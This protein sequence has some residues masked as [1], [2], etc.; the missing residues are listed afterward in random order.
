MEIQ[1][2]SLQREAKHGGSSKHSWSTAQQLAG[3]TE[4]LQDCCACVQRGR[5]R[6]SFFT[7]ISRR[8]KKQEHK[9]TAFESS[10]LLQHQPFVN[11]F[12]PFSLRYRAPISTEISWLCYVNWEAWYWELLQTLCSHWT[13]Q[14]VIP[15]R[16]PWTPCSGWLGAQMRKPMEK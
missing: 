12:C 11:F 4:A 6:F 16:Q 13:Q 15:W 3:M 14:S 8:R 2:Q 5:I 10:P 9:P 7:K 1:G